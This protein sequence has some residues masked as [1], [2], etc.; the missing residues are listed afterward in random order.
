MGKFSSKHI[1]NCL[2]HFWQGLSKSAHVLKFKYRFT[3]TIV[4]NYL[5]AI[6][7]EDFLTGIAQPKLNQAK[8][9]IIPIP[10]PEE[11]EEEKIADC[12]ESAK[13]CRAQ[14]P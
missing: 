11:D 2:L 12:L 9:E 14:N 3:Q 7:L 5:N 1:S 4:E 8:L 13:A 10:L 6:S